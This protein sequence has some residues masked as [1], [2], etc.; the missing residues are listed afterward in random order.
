MH[1]DRISWLALTQT[2]SSNGLAELA[3]AYNECAEEQDILRPDPNHGMVKPYAV[4][5][6]R[7]RIT[8]TALQRYL[9]AQID[10]RL[11]DGSRYPDLS[12]EAEE[13]IDIYG[14]RDQRGMLTLG[15]LPRSQ[16]LPLIYF[17]MQTMADIVKGMRQAQRGLEHPPQNI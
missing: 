17:L 13:L 7:L 8:Q 12:E 16:V 6:D 3:M 9:D 15:R 2:A 11:P 10:T 5:Q 14:G 1:S 4:Y